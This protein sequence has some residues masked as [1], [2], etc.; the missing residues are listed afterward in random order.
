MNDVV[1]SASFE[2]R[3]TRDR[4][5]GDLRD[6]KND[7]QGFASDAERDLNASGGRISSG[8]SGLVSK[9]AVAVAAFGGVLALAAMGAFK[10]GQASLSMAE[11]IADT[12]NRVNVSTA[13]LQ[14]W[15][16]VAQRTGEDAAAAD[17]ALESFAKKL[18][19]AGAGNKEALAIFAAIGID[20]D[21]IRSFQDTEQALD[22]VIDRIGDLSSEA[23]RSAWAEKLGLGPLSTALQLGSDKIAQMRDEARDAGLVIDDA[24][25]QK[26]AEAADKMDILGQVVSNQLASAFLTASEEVINFTG[27]ISDALGALNRLIARASEWRQRADI[28]YGKDAVDSF[29]KGNPTPMAR[30]GAGALLSGRAVDVERAFKLPDDQDDPFFIRQQMSIA[31]ARRRTD[32]DGPS[33][34]IPAPDRTR[35]R[36]SRAPRDTSAQDARRATE[37]AERREAL[38]LQNA[39]DIARASGDEAALRAAEERMDVARL[40]AAFE[41]AGF[42]DAEFRATA[43]VAAMNEA[44]AKAEEREKADERSR[45]LADQE[46][47]YRQRAAELLS[48]QLADQIELARLSGDEGLLGSLLREEEIR[49]RIAEL[50]R[51]GIAKTEDGARAL[52]TVAVDDADAAERK[53]AMR[54]E[55]RSAFTDGIQAAIDGDLGSFFDSLADRFTTRMLDN[56]ADDLFDLL[57][58]AMAGMGKGGGGGGFLSSALSFGASLFSGSMGAPSGSLA[59]IPGLK[60][61]GVAGALSQASAGIGKADPMKVIIDVIDDRFDAY[62]DKRAGPMATDAYAGAVGT[63]RSVVPGEMAKR[64]A[65]RTR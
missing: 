7:L 54:D 15:R 3:A 65:Y 63:S 39:L 58:S 9:A 38:T 12:A 28:I 10:L 30:A 55:F 37:L 57:S 43:Q 49:R 48:A 40:T 27:T 33:D 22:V 44:L 11:N 25:I 14:E 34:L 36:R 61:A 46:V 17:Q 1:G 24:L 2:I 13:A 56:L 50:M 42:D 59:S 29:F 23:D 31:D 6:A 20:Q 35:S 53:G 16:A 47:E 26:G 8:I 4:M 60:S 18:N 62:V 32:E 64:Q 21:R 41:R 5:K 19:D 51:F 52:A 45:K